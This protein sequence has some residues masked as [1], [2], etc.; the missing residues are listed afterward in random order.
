[1][2]FEDFEKWQNRRF[3]DLAELFVEITPEIETK[4]NDFCWERYEKERQQAGDIWE[5]EDE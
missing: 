1:M 2:S 5:L 3:S 4:F